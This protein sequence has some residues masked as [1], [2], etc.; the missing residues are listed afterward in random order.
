[1]RDRK[2][3]INTI[4]DTVRTPCIWITNTSHDELDISN[5]RRFDYSIRFDKLNRAQRK[6]IWQNAAQKYAVANSL[7]DT[8][9]DRLAE[10]YE[11]SAGGINLAVKNLVGLM[12]DGPTS[13]EAV[14]QSISCILDPH[15]ELMEI[16][17][18][19]VNLQACQDYS[20]EGLRLKTPIPLE[21]IEKA[22]RCFLKEQKEVTSAGI[23]RPRMNLLLSGPPGTGKTEFVKHLGHTLDHRV[24]VKMGSDLISMWVGGTEKNIRTAFREA[25]SQRAVLFMDEFDGLMQSRGHA[26]HSWEITQ[27]NELLQQMENF[28]GIFIAATNFCENLDAAAIRRFTF[29]VDFDYLDASGKLLFFERFFNRALDD[30]QRTCLGAI[31]NLTPGDF[32][33]V[34]QSLFYQGEDNTVEDILGA[35]QVESRAKVQGRGI[36]GR[37]GF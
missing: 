13:T 18:G 9:T 19:S 11:V 6:T 29:K 34:R 28:D 16:K 35:L 4:L 2:G 27:V 20:L 3:E 24:V 26:Q 7:P 31:N 30:G 25:S 12:Q 37:L 32:R 10:L 36:A 5:R 8:L 17:R 33:T 22:M 21:R 15:C 23:D 14:Q 1:L